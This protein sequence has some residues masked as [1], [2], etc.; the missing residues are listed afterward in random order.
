M[1]LGEPVGGD[2]AYRRSWPRCSRT[3]SRW[4]PSCSGCPTGR[5]WPPCASGHRGVGH[6]HP[7]GRREGRRRPGVDAVVVQ[8]TEAGGHRGGLPD[9]DDYAV[10]PLLRLAASRCDLP[11]VAAGGIVDGPALAAVLAAGAAAA[12]LG[13]AF[14]RCRRRAA[15]RYTGPRWPVPRPPR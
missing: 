14:L 8:G 10:L 9:D 2:D 7:S 15:R 5:R 12:Q 13:T 4:C 3:R 11:L 1:S 6:G